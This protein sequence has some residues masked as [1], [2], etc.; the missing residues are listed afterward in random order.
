M[1]ECL[2]DVRHTLAGLLGDRLAVGQATGG[3]ATSLI[4]VNE[5]VEPDDYWN[6][7]R[8][9]IYSGPGAPQE[10]IISDFTQ[11]TRSI[12]VSPTWTAVNGSSTYEIHRAFSVLDHYNPMIKMALRSRRKRHMLAKEDETVK[13]VADTYEYSIPTGF[14]SI[15]EIWRQNALSQF[16]EPIPLDHVYV[17]R[18]GKKLV[19][20]KQVALKEGHI[21]ADR[22]LRLIGQQ[23]QAEP[24][25]ESSEITVNTTPIIWL[26]KAMLHANKGEMNEMKAAIQMSEADLLEDE[27]LLWPG[28]LVVEEV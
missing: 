4:D 20:E 27:T 22:Y 28:S 19:F 13:L 17:L 18:S 11:S 24:S 25:S 21:I 15:S 9:Y 10:R 12:T 26:A 14:V 1:A 8:I 23:Y 16:V 6:G 7:C 5:R 2:Y 3:S